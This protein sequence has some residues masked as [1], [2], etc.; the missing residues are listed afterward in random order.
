MGPGLNMLPL[1]E[2]D[3]IFLSTSPNTGASM[4]E[5]IGK[6]LSQSSSLGDR[7]D[8][9]TKLQITHYHLF[10]LMLSEVSG[11]PVRCHRMSGL[12]QS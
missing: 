10:I 5:G 2:K 12:A 6:S 1:V 11:F 8:K 3:L 9:L 7:I 4:I